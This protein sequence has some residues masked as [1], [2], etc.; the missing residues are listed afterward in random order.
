MDERSLIL[1]LTHLIPY[2]RTEELEIYYR[3]EELLKSL[4]DYIKIQTRN[5][6]FRNIFN[7]SPIET[8]IWL[9]P[10]WT[11][12]TRNRKLHRHETLV[13]APQI[14]KQSSPY[15]RSEQWETYIPFLANHKAIEMVFLKDFYPS[16]SMY[17]HNAVMAHLVAKVLIFNSLA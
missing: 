14:T 4:Y 3:K 2:I 17:G 1:G 16:A 8:K 11:Y 13:R 10:A 15:F 9:A 5:T 6:W 12:N 7:T